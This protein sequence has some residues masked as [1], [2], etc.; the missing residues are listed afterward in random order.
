M[1]YGTESKLLITIVSANVL[2]FELFAFFNFL[3]FLIIMNFQQ[4]QFFVFLSFFES[5]FLLQRNDPYKGR[6]LP[7]RYSIL[8]SFLLSSF[9][10][11]YSCIFEMTSVKKMFSGSWI[12]NTLI[13]F[14]TSSNVN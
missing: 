11:L 5:S 4:F 10:F 14:T 7:N 3:V 9:I 8:K 2:H 12:S 1:F 6:K 13:I